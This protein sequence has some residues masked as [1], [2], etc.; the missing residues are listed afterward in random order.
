MSEVITV[1]ELGRILDLAVP[2]LDRLGDD[3]F[4]AFP[5]REASAMGVAMAGLFATSMT[6][7]PDQQSEQAQ[8]LN[9][10]LGR[11]GAHRLPWRL[12]PA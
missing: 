7:N 11:W 5:G 12:V 3:L 9:A 2:H 6:G 8:V 1:H 4:Q 10:I